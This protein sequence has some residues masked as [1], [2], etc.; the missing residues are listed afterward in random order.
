M[1]S[2]ADEFQQDQTPT[3]AERAPGRLPT[4]RGQRW[5]AITSSTVGASLRPDSASSAPRSRCGIGTLRSTEKTA[6]ASVGEV[7]APS[8]MAIHRSRPEH[9][10]AEQGHQRRR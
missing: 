2:A 8:R 3:S 4:A 7:T 10:V 9:V 1:A 6:A 5:P